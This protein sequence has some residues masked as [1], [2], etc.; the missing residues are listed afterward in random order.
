MGQ[1]LLWAAKG[2]NTTTP[3]PRVGCVIVKQ[4]RVIGAGHTQP[5]GQAHAEIQALNDARAN[6][7]D[8]SDATVYVN[9]EPCSHFGRTPPCVDALIEAK[10]KRVVV[11]LK[12]PYPEVAGRG[13]DKLRA[14]GILVLTDV[15][16]EEAREINLGFLSRFERGLPWVRMKLAASLDGK[17]ALN[18]GQSQWITSQ[19]A[20][21]DG[22]LWRARACAIL[23]GIGTV[24][25]DDPQLTVRAIETTRQPRRIVL[26]SSLEIDPSAKVL[27]GGGT[28]IVAAQSNPDKEA[29]LREKGAEIILL[30]GEDGQVDLKALM[31]E[32]AKRHINELHVEAGARLNGALLAQGCVDEILLYLAPSILG[33]AQPMFALPALTNL[34]DKHA[35]HFRDIAQIGDD[36]RIIARIQPKQP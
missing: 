21:N 9:L 19:P 23:T 24:Q 4:G 12:D 31:H 10:V 28:W 35:L 16:P 34:A 5:V 17:T 6:G 29:A 20:R 15:R 8:V 7:H 11:A 3:N 27:D 36:L 22:H 2:M 1:A 26:D 25:A 32:L 33:D 13:L 14:A 18:N 30:P